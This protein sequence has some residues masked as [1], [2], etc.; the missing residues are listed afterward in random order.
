M[1][2]PA[3]IPQPMAAR[4][5]KFVAD[6]E[7][8]QLPER[9][10]EAVRAGIVDFGACRFIGE[11]ELVVQAIVASLDTCG[12]SEEA[13][14][15]FAGIRCSAAEAALVNA[16]AAHAS[17]IDDNALRNNHVS[18]VL[19]ATALAAA[20]ATG[21]DGRA[22]VTGYVAGYEVWARLVAAEANPYGPKGWHSTAVLGPVAAAAT[23]SSIAGLN[24]TQAQAAIATA[25]SASGGLIANFNDWVKPWQVGR[26]AS[27]GITAAK[28]AK[29]GFRGGAGALD[30]GN[31]L[32]AALS[33]AGK[34]D[35]TRDMDTLGS[36]WAIEREGV[37][38]KRYPWALPCHRALD[39]IFE[40]LDQ[41]P[42][43]PADVE[44]IKVVIGTEEESVLA[45]RRV[46]E[47]RPLM[48]VQLAIAAAIISGRVGAQEY[49]PAFYDRADVRALMD[50]ISI[51]VRDAL[52]PDKDPNLGYRSALT[53]RMSDGSVRTSRDIQFPLGNWSS[54]LSA[55]QQWGKFAEAAEPAIGP[56]R[57]RR[58]FDRLR[59]IDQVTDLA[60][61]AA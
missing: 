57:A 23:A 49:A 9:A 41:A 6:L 34:L 15:G 42:I 58:L 27:T 14:I 39:G 59:A 7:F 44:S 12:L 61:I 4:F 1:A 20:E 55:E 18:S 26:A 52:T 38:I 16:A 31:G 28:L 3:P 53:V 21:R 25:A 8:E 40:L 45:S 19:A 54:P 17:H 2:D 33:P 37:N 32:L 51:S 50:K 60:A 48:S 22:V 47:F 35:P 10:V 46:P 13:S 5:G 24:A 29:A 56:D 36:D 11:H 30:A 43:D